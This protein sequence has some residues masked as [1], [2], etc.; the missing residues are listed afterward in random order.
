VLIDPPGDWQ[1]GM[2]AIIHPCKRYWLRVE[3]PHDRALP[4]LSYEVTQSMTR[5]FES[6]ERR[7]FPGSPVLR[8]LF[9]GLLDSQRHSALYAEEFSARCSTRSS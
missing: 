1:G 3:F 2:D 9:S 8:D 5:S 4:G 7:F 6:F